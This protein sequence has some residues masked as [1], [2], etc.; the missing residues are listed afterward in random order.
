MRRF[1]GVLLACVLLAGCGGGSEDGKIAF[2]SDRDGDEEIFVMNADGTGVQ[3]LTDNDDSDWFPVWSPNGKKIAFHS[4]RDGDFEVFVMN[5]DGTGV[6]QLT[7]HDDSD[8]IPVW[9]PDGKKIVFTSDRYGDREIF[10]MNADGSNVVSLGQQGI[11]G[12]WGG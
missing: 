10:V 1:I 7:D 2:T 5:A 6:T 3:Q 9:S 8:W 12:S 4:D 11:P